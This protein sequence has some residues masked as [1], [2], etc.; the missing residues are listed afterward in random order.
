[1]GFQIALSGLNAATSEL[2]ATANNIANV[3]ST[4][5]KSSTTNF[6]D[7]YATA[8]NSISSTTVGGGVK[9]MSV[10]QDFS[11]GTINTTN[12]DLDMAISGNGFFVMKGSSGMTYTRNGAFSVDNNG[13]VVNDSGNR[14]QVFPT[15][16]GG[17]FATGSL[18]DL[19]LQTTN[20]P[21]L[22]TSS[23]NIGVNLAAN[24]T[25]PTDT[26][27]PTDTASYNNATSMTIYDSMGNAHSATLY[28][29]KQLD[30]STAAAN[31]T[32]AQTAL[33]ANPSDATLQAAVTTAQTAAAGAVANTWTE[34]LY[35]DG[36]QVGT[37]TT[38]TFNTNG[39][40][41]SPTGGLVTVPS[42]TAS[43]GAA[44]INMTLNFSAATQYGDA[45]AVN[46]LTQN[47]YASG[48]MT[49]ISVDSTGVVSANFTNGQLKQLGKLAIANFNDPNGLQQQGG[50]SWAET[51]AS[52]SARLG[53]A[54][55][56]DFGSVQSGALE[57]SNVNLTSQLVQMINAQ[58]NFQANAQM[59]QT[60][61][62]ITQTMLN[63]Q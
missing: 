19:Q 51:Y 62:K 26:F 30:P 12:N 44:P 41:Q 11:Q 16:Q 57:S 43:G 52:G 28:F 59:I 10:S 63:M 42:F 53:Q 14:L 23:A 54:S 8:S 6:A 4:G 35:V 7:V 33:A 49:G 17:G 48:R 27:S 56:S 55:T 34:N 29:T 39:T 5:F 21:P 32:A 22:V 24:A 60:D 47:G 13:Y 36:N 3:D 46:N 20:S 40:L 1:M 61:D 9:V 31:I 2:D 50:T 25:V 58:R 38:M 37:P 45:F 18:S 15:G